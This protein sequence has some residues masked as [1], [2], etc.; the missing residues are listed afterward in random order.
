LHKAQQE[1]AAQ[2]RAHIDRVVECAVHGGSNC[3]GI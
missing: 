3:D 2:R 1:S